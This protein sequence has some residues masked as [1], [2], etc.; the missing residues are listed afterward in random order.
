[1]ANKPKKSS[2]PKLTPAQ[3]KKLEERKRTDNP[4]GIQRRYQKVALEPSQRGGYKTR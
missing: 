4:T 2:V 3:M 1:M